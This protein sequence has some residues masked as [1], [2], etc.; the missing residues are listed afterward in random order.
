MA[1]SL[2]LI[3]FLNVYICVVEIDEETKVVKNT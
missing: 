3:I 1:I 2:K